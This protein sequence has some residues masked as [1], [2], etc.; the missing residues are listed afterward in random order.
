MMN[1]ESS[2]KKGIVVVAETAPVVG[3]RTE[4]TTGIEWCGMVRGGAM[5]RQWFCDQAALVSR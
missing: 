4:T 5:S 1:E 2:A 3:E